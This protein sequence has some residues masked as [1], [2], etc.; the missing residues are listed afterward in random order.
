MSLLDLISLKT[1]TSSISFSNLF[2]TLSAHSLLAAV[3]IE[4]V[5]DIQD[6]LT[7]REIAPGRIIGSVFED[8]EIKVPSRSKTIVSGGRE[9]S[10][11]VDICVREGYVIVLGL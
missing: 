9:G 4:R 7:S 10:S 8:S 1:F 11:S 2:T 5:Q 6:R 3:Q